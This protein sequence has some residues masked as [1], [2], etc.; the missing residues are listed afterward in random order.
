[1]PTLNES[2]NS[3]ALIYSNSV[4]LQIA[5]LLDDSLAF[6]QPEPHILVA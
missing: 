1:M 2:K 3:L 4:S 5:S 6:P